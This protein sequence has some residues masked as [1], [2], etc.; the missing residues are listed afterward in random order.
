[1]N[2]TAGIEVGTTL[3]GRY[4]DQYGVPMIIAVNQMDHDKANWDGVR[5]AISEE[6]GKKAILCQFPVNPGLGLEGFVDVITSLQG[7]KPGKGKTAQR[8]HA[9]CQQFEFIYVSAGVR[10]LQFK[11]APQDLIQVAHMTVAELTG[12]E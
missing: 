3:F 2:G 11:L 7:G 10:G 8:I 12:G 4:A 5:N 6:F 9:T 1:M